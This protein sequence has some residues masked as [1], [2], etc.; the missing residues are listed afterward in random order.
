[1]SECA[2]ELALEAAAVENIQQ[3]IDV[4]ARLEVADARARDG[5]LALEALDFRPEATR[6]VEKSRRKD[7]LSGL[8]THVFSPRES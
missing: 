1:M 7:V 4:G 3:R 8:E 5:K 6:P 2:L